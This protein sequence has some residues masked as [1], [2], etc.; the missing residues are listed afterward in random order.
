M[1]P[2]P[3]QERLHELFYCVNGK[4]IRKVT[5]QTTAIR[6]DVAGGINSKGY[7]NV[8]VDG[9][10]Y[11][12]HRLVWKWYYGTDPVEFIDHIDRNPRNNNIWNLR[13]VTRTQNNHNNTRTMDNHNGQ[14]QSRTI[15]GKNMRTDYG[16]RVM[17]GLV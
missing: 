8:R 9:V 5:T 12:H 17:R 1:K 14:L 2:L 13:D 7:T 6:G 3:T 11:K 10:M 15:N 16:I 4:F